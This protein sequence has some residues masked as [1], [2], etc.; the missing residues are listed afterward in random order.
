M[1]H[2][3]FY[4]QCLPLLESSIHCGFDVS[5]CT[6]SLP[7]WSI[8]FYSHCHDST[9]LVLLSR[10]H[11]LLIFLVFIFITPLMSML[12]KQPLERVLNTHQK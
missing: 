5:P 2:V 6:H 9:L 11:F 7:I 10:I 8:P 3:V 12:K 4:R 1:I